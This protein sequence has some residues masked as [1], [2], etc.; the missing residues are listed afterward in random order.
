MSVIHVAV[1][2][3]M[4]FVKFPPLHKV[5]VHEGSV[6]PL[7]QIAR[8][9]RYAAAVIAGVASYAM[10]MFLMSSSTLASVGCGLSPTKTPV[11]IF[12]HVM[13]MYAPSFFTG[14]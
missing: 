3:L 13:G 2:R 7:W 5:D 8:Q 12:V 9:P 11:T 4:G 1:F 14:T 10:M 6:R